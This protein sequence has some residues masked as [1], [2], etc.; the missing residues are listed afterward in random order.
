MAKR[1]KEEAPDQEPDFKIPAFDEEKYIKRE[2]RNIKTIFLSF[3]LGVGIAIIS[4]GFWALLTGHFLQW[5]LVLLFGVINAS[6]LRYLFTKINIDLD[7]FGRRGWLTAF[8]TYI[9]TWL[10]ILIVLVNPP[11]YDSEPPQIQAVSLPSAQTPGGTVLIAATVSDNVHVSTVNFTY[12]DPQGTTHAPPT[13]LQNGIL[14]FLYDQNT[15]ALGQYTYTLTATDSNGHRTTVTGN[16]T[17]TNNA[18][19][20]TSS[21]PPAIRSGDIVSIKADPHISKESFRVYYRINDGTQINTT[22]TD[23][24]HYQTTPEFSGWTANS[25]LTLRLYAEV[26][27]YFLNNPLRYSNNV[28]SNSTYTFSTGIDPSIGATPDPKPNYALPQP[29]IQSATPGFEV[30][31]ALSALAVVLLVI[32]KKKTRK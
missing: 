25:T 30:L 18:L 28:T 22:R 1:Y 12:T 5:E 13:S 16:F 10:L 26:S 17:Y 20:I 7:G 8:G 29:N 2:R 27:H 14:L 24:E 3:L 4:F 23:P 11:F 6:W 15:T 9:F 31:L 19:S 32:R 21:I